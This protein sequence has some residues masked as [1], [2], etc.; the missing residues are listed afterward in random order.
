MITPYQD[1]LVTPG[2]SPLKD[3]SLKQSLH[4]SNFLYTERDLPH[5]LHLLLCLTSYF[6]FLK[7]FAIVD[8]FATVI[9]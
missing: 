9:S 4:N 2:I 1:A 5:T 7:C 8:F 3:N 6:F